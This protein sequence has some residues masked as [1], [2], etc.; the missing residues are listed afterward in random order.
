MLESMTRTLTQS[1]MLSVALLTSAQAQTGAQP[2][3]QRSSDAIR[4]TAF[5]KGV[6][7]LKRGNLSR[8]VV[9][10]LSGCTTGTYDGSDPKSRPSGGAA[11]A[12]V[13]D[14]VSHGGFWYLT[15]Q[16]TLNSGCNVQGLNGACSEVTLLW[17]KLSADLRLAAKQAESV[18]SC[19]DQTTLTGWSGAGPDQDLEFPSPAALG[20]SRGVLAFTYQTPETLDVNAEFKNVYTLRYDHAAPERGLRVVSQRVPIK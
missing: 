10:P 14:L 1:L 20:L 16:A 19:A 3:Q 8:R 7:D 12:R 11:Q 18:S 2:A 17:L 5:L 6:F 13:I 9:V 15:M 4:V